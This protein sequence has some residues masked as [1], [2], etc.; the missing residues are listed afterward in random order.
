MVACTRPSEG[1]ASGPATAHNSSFPGISRHLLGQ[2][3]LITGQ[4]LA[5]LSLR[6]EWARWRDQ[7]AHLD[8]PTRVERSSPRHPI[9]SWKIPPAWSLLADSVLG[10][11]EGQREGT[12]GKAVCL[13][14]PPRLWCHD[15][16]L[17]SSSVQSLEEAQPLRDPLALCMSLCFPELP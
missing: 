4:A 8:F 15:C 7:R 6:H 9:S 5:Q 1:S 17:S 13:P 3:H 11:C 12:P 16:P 2:E 10:L 14:T